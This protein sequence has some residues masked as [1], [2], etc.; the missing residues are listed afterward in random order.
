MGRKPKWELALEAMQVEQAKRLRDVAQWML[1]AATEYEDEYKR[2]VLDFYHPDEF[3][4]CMAEI[5]E[6][7]GN[8]VEVLDLMAERLVLRATPI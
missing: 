2:Q 5:A 1:T 4:A 7:S 3:S 8:S 6:T